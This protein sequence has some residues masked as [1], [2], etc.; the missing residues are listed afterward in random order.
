MNNVSIEICFRLPFLF[1]Y[2]LIHEHRS[3]LK[4]GN[5]WACSFM[6]LKG[7][8]GWDARCWPSTH[9]S[10]HGCTA[11]GSL[12]VLHAYRDRC[13]WLEVPLRWWQDQEV[14]VSWK[15]SKINIDL[16]LSIILCA[17]GLPTQMFNVHK[18][19]QPSHLLIYRSD[20]AVLS[21]VATLHFSSFF[22]AVEKLP[23]CPGLRVWVQNTMDT[24]EPWTSQE[25]PNREL[26]YPLLL[27]G[28]LSTLS[29]SPSSRVK[30]RLWFLLSPY[31]LFAQ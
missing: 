2:F 22:K 19:T 15:W 23:S 31:R 16:K 8:D 12:L 17:S 21:S 26:Q 27:Q 20:E 13:Q 18:T 30:V 14:F 9:S 11:V 1:V 24:S 10:G 4:S 6:P 7:S 3:H 5:K 25:L 28:S 29:K